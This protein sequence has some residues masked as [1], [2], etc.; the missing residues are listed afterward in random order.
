MTGSSA[1]S[2]AINVVVKQPLLDEIERFRRGQ[3]VIPSRPAA[4]RQLL[5][6]AVNAQ[7]AT[8]DEAAAA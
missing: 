5:Q 6:Q 7:H 3:A 4:V 8:G 1:E 2:K